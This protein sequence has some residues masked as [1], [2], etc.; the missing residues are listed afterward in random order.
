TRPLR[1]PSAADR[2]RARLPEGRA[3]CRPRRAHVAPRSRERSRRPRG[4]DG[5]LPRP[6]GAAHRAPADHGLH[7]R[8]C[9]GARSR[10]RSRRGDPSL[11]PGRRRL[12]RLPSGRVGRTIMSARLLRL[13]APGWPRFVAASLL[14]AATLGSGLG[15][16]A[17]SGWLLARAAEHPSIGALSVA[18]V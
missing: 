12:L 5:A 6:D 3:R 9:R 10:P 18:I 1:R 14:L 7:R 13:L 11:S 16:M 15:L 4:D 2:P 8:P 17:S